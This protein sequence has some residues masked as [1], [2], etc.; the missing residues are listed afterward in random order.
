MKKF[1]VALCSILFGLTSYS[2]EVNVYLIGDAGKP[3]L[4]DDSNLQYLASQFSEATENDYLIFLGDNVYPAG[5]PTK[6]DPLREKAENRLKPSLDLIK[7][8]P[9]KSFILPGNHD[10]KKGTR[11]G[12]EQIRQMQDY[13]DEYL[14]DQTVFQ[15]RDACPGPV[16]ISISREITLVLLDTQYMLHPWEKPGGEEGCDSKSTTDAI[17]RLEEIIKANKNKHVL[18]AGHHPMYSKGPHGGVYTFKQHLFPLTDVKRKLWIPLP[19]IGSIYP[20]YRTLIGNA[21]DIPH[22]RYRL[23]RN[24]IVEMM[25]PCANVVYVNGHEHSLQYIQRE[26]HHFITSGAGSKSSNVKKGKYSKFAFEGRGFAKLTYKNAQDVTATFYDGDQQKVL[27]TLELY[28]KSVDLPEQKKLD[29]DFKD[30]TVIVPISTRYTGASKKKK[31]WLGANYRELW[32]EPVE[33]P[34]FNIGK[35]HGGL[36]ILKMGGGN[37]T[38]SLRLETSE[39][40][41]YVLRSLEKYTEK[42]I[43]IPL[44]KTL[45]ADLLQDQISASN[46]YGAFVIPPMADAIGIYHTNPKLVYIPDDPRF[47]EYNK[48]FKGLAVLYE[49]RPNDEAAFET[50]FGEGEDIKGTD[51]L[52]E[53]L[54]KD[55]DEI[56]D[57]P[58]ALRSRLFDMI[59]GDWDRHDDQWRWVAFDNEND[60]G[61][62]WRPI[63]RDRDQAFFQPDGVFAW[64]ATKK[65]ALPNTEGFYPEMRYPPG[66]NTSA[67]FFDR[68][69]I[70]ELNW[71]AWEKE[72]NYIQAHLTDEAIEKAFE[73][74]PASISAMK[75]EETIQILKARRDDMPRFARIHYEFLSREVE[76][77]GSN[78][79][80]QF[81]VE[82]MPD[83]Q[84]KVTV[85]KL[86][87]KNKVSRLM[88][89]RTFM[90]SETKEIRLYGFEDKDVFQVSGEGQEGIKV[91][92]IGGED[93][94]D[95]TDNSK[96]RGIGK[97]TLVYDLKSNTNL[98]ASN[99]TQSRL[100]NN[101]MVNRYDRRGFKYNKTIP[102]VTGAFNQDD[103]LFLG[104]GFLH[105][106]QGW[107]KDPFSSKHQLTGNVALATASFNFYY[108]GTLNDIIG[109]WDLNA[110]FSYQRPFGVS[111]YFGLG[112]KS[113]F[114]YRGEAA[115][116]SFDDEVDFYRIRYERSE[117]FISLGRHL[118]QKGMLKIG[119]EY[120]R[121]DL[122]R[123]NNRF[124]SSP[125]SD[126]DQS[127]IY[128]PFEYLGYRAEIQADTRNHS[129]LPSKGLFANL[130]VENLLSLKGNADDINRITGEFIFYLS[131]K[132][133]AKVILGNRIGAEHNFNDIAFFNGAS[134]GRDN[135]RGY[136]RS[137]FIGNSSVYH[138]VDLRVNLFTFRTYLLPV[139]VGLL[140][141]HDIGR[142]WLNGESSVNWHSSKGFGLWLSPLNQVAITAMLAFS[143]EETLPMV[144]LGFQF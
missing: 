71:E 43:P 38:K 59:I 106:H 48:T 104:G 13:V 136:R 138:N 3:Q 108:N 22:P 111:N 135:I 89:E 72:I 58:F 45:A 95:I 74:W 82:R 27:E 98:T 54:R 144:S 32:A 85:N 140:G 117:N 19:V 53:E 99:E 21:Q 6:E 25:E 127:K 50:F 57:Q 87:K 36:N 51:D 47:G 88:F 78:D 120:F 42:L 39:G 84:T 96:V 56:I 114:D 49:E 66:F 67:R 70:H 17:L 12:W 55:N 31:F 81:L 102:I 130:K 52:L 86:S 90:P 63:P 139:G 105:Y 29:F 115:T 24:A 62:T 80:E 61:H 123:Q 11:G 5:I 20:L 103:G 134:V 33:M 16:E 23:V 129:G 30:S 137:R 97:K 40:R 14:G 110:D 133:P 91:R 92:I 109:K 41:Q 10:W 46:P 15:P 128:E 26:G 121:Y 76:V 122:T 44:Q 65:F 35:E 79:K 100:S 142:V 112:N 37:Q 107:R 7:A 94:D 118:G 125:E 75:A 73:L 68:T 141:F 4:P 8:F 28:N 9:G 131:T 132:I 69:F 64:I 77:T 83:G 101:I 116:N 124:I 93:E 119:P 34:V 113:Q 2:Q 126:L 60:K 143:E 1:L 18:I